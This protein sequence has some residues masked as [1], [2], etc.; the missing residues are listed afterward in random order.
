MPESATSATAGAVAAEDASGT[1]PRPDTPA[2][3]RAAGS[4]LSALVPYGV[5]IVFGI[6]IAVF[7]VMAPEAFPTTTNLKSILTVQ[8]VLAV[9]ALGVTIPLIC[10]QFDLSIGANISIVGLITAGLMSRTGLAW[11][12]AVIV[13]LGLGVLVGVLNGVL[14]AYGGVHSFIATLGTGTLIGGFVLWYSGGRMIFENIAPAYV[15]LMRGSLAGIPLP[16]FYTAIV[17]VAVWFALTH[18]PFGRYLYAIGGNRA[19]AQ[20][21]G[22]PVRRYVLYSL[23]SSGALAGLAGVM[24]ASRSASAQTGAGDTYLLPAFAAAFIGAATFRRGEF[25]AW[26]TVVGVYFVATL[27][28]GAFILGARDYVN[29]IITGVALIL[30]VLGNRALAD[31]S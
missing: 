18:T 28:S 13:G 11:E 27:V 30:A 6:A 22:V 15:R 26:G 5:L 23:I 12:A 7:S 9:A 25:N 24:L 4:L 1:P 17:T 3:R 19:A 16:V 21:A 29:P 10:G 8:S 14:V 20:V 31:K 2:R